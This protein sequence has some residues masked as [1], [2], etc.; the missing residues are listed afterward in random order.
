M[1]HRTG[2]LGGARFAVSDRWG[3]VSAGPYGE[4]NLAGHVGDDPVA[5]AENRNRLVS[6][7]GLAPDR[8]SFMSQVHGHDV[9]VLEAL[10]VPGAPPPRVDALVSRHP[11]VALAVLAADCVPILLSA[12]S[13]RGTV[14]GAAHA[15]RRGVQT[16][17]VAATVEAMRS[18]GARPEQCSAL[19]GPAVCAGCYEVPIEMAAEV[20]AGLPAARATSSSGTPALDL[21]GAVAAQLR[22]E[23]IAEVVVDGTCTAEDPSLYSYR[24]DGV[25]GRLGGLVWAVG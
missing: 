18:L 14:V 11:G 9:A 5:V 16:G 19:V 23:G 12:P 15:G 10:P 4:L 13:S 24:R 3:G 8:V 20:G 6:A 1:L 2:S 21:P 17:V 22:A 25:T 7:V